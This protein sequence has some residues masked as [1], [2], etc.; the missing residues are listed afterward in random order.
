[1]TNLRFTIQAQKVNETKNIV[2]VVTNTPRPMY[3]PTK[4]TPRF[5]LFPARFGEMGLLRAVELNKLLSN[6]K[7]S[8][9]IN[10]IIV[11]CMCPLV[12]IRKC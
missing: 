2:L 10:T 3:Q 1:M 5:V 9:I 12:Y 6:G 7:I 8:L 11:I 4:D